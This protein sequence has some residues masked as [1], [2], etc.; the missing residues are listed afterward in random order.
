MQRPFW[1]RWT[2]W[3][4]WTSRP[5]ALL[6]RASPGTLVMPGEAWASRNAF[7]ACRDGNGHQ[8]LKAQWQMSTQLA[9]ACGDAGFSGFC[10]LC[11]ARCRFGRAGDAASFDVR[12]GLACEGC[13]LNARMR[14][15]LSLLLEGLD[16]ASARVYLTEQASPGFVWLQ[17]QVR[18]AEGSEFG[19]DAVR[20]KRLQRWYEGMGGQGALAEADITALG[21]PDA[22]LDAIGCFDVLEHVPDYRAALREFARV[23]VPG[24]RLLLTLPFAETEQDTL[25]RARVRADGSI[26]HIE[27]EEVHGDPV[28]GGVLC[29]YHFGWDLLDELRAAGFR[30]AEW[31]RSFVPEYA[32]FGIWALRAQR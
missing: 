28:S 4:R 30:H 12:E 14:H 26:E 8:R 16:R 19:L 5:T 18:H 25:V 24:G 22:S 27:P 9:A 6:R 10:P 11:A 29:Y 15:A 32:I 7:V 31:V 3:M 21:R 2:G 1:M 20:R 13:G 23:L 17:A